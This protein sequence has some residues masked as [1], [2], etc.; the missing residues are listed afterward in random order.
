MLFGS[1]RF[2]SVRGGFVENRSGLG[3]I[4]PGSIPTGINFGSVQGGFGPVGK[5]GP[6]ELGLVGPKIKN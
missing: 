6:T 4:I 2:G 1:V 5:F 3:Y